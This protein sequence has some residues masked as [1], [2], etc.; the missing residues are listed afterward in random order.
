MVGVDDWKCPHNS[1]ILYGIY[2]DF[3]PANK[4]QEKTLSYLSFH[5][6]LVAFTSDSFMQC[7]PGA[8]LIHTVYSMKMPEYNIMCIQPRK[9]NYNN[10]YSV[11]EVLLKG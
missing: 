3:L 10:V 2:M 1:Y 5:L 9:R 8:W 7:C 11:N 4:A 6:S